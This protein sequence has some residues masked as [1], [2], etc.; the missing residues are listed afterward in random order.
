VYDV[1]TF[2][3][4]G[5]L[6]DWESGIS[7]ALHHAAKS[8]GFDVRR[9]DIM[10]AYLE[11]ENAAFLADSLGGWTP[12]ADTNQALEELNKDGYRLGILSNIDNDLL[13]GTLEHLTVE[14]DF[15]VTAESVR[16][17]KP[18]QAHFLKA[19]ESLAGSFWLHAAQ[20]YFHDIVPACELDIPVVWVNRNGETPGRESCPTGEVPT[21]GGL[22]QWLREGRT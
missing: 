13:A 6:I 8:I 9:V 14:F 15:L 5:T 4:Y 19:R 1:I 18:A 16:S 10:R 2:D 12:F 20:S 3:C 7:G 11:V 22:V 21:L 17:Y